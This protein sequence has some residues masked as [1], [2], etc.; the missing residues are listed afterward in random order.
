MVR[1]A[2][3]ALARPR[4][5][6]APRPQTELSTTTI[7][8]VAPSGRG[9]YVSLGAATL[10]VFG[11]SYW[12]FGTGRPGVDTNKPVAGAPGSVVLDVL[13]WAN[14]VAI[15]RKADGAAVTTAC[16]VTPCVASLPAGEYR[17]KASN[18]NFPDPVEFDVAVEAGGVREVRQSIPGFKAEDEVSKI[19]AK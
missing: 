15:T 6:L 10:V 13:P 1:I 8:P 11:I 9:K 18:P 3:A 4:P 14:I 16:T 12:L 19:L 2:D 7:E 5:D 17:V